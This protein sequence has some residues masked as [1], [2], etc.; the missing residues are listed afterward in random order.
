MRIEEVSPLKSNQLAKDYSQDFERIDRFFTYNPYEG[1][2]WKG[3][4]DWLAASNIKHRDQLTEALL[5]YNQGVGNN[6]ALGNIEKLKNEDVF[7]IIGGQQAGV[8]TG[9]LHVIHKAVTILQLCRDVE[10]RKGIKV[11]PVFWIASEDHDY[12]EV[13]HTYVETGQEQNP[14]K[15]QLHKK[16]VQK[17][18]L[19][20]L[21]IN[22]AEFAHV[23]Q[24]CFSYLPDS[25]HQPDLLATLL[26]FSQ[27][28]K[29]LPDFFA[30]IMAW[31][32]EKH[33]LV[34]V[35]S[36]DPKIRELEKHVF[37]QLMKSDPSSRLLST[38]K[39]LQEIGYPS[40]LEVEPENAHFFVYCNGERELMVRK[41]GGFVSK[42]GRYAFSQNE[43]EQLLEENPSSFSANVVTRPIMQEHLF[44]VLAFVGGP[45][46]VA[47]WAQLKGI[48]EMFSMQMPIVYPRMTFTIVERSIEKYMKRFGI[49][50]F[51]VHDRWEQLQKEWLNQQ[52]PLPLESEFRSLK[53]Q[54][55]TLYLPFLEKLVQIEP[56]VEKL[57]EDNLSRILSH[58][59]F[60]EKKTWDATVQRHRA[61][62]IQW[63]KVR[64]SL[65]PLEKPQERVYN[66]FGY[67]NTYGTSFI[68]ELVE[69]RIPLTAN[70]KLLYI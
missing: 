4:A 33:G 29:G 64:N 69:M 28:S 24:Q 35:D 25:Q 58:L 46:E 16:V 1:N 56:G 36:A 68:D 54:V 21:E 3:R 10:Q 6:G 42:T 15:I 45:G 32:F 11:V 70:H 30:R 65:F 34:L 53:S 39:E 60:L 40:Q 31:L 22:S 12:D 50:F 63:E 8:L 9:P 37:S 13:N 48:F 52:N 57:G 66:V 61:A 27:Q 23:I 7:V 26:D 17:K 44:P 59:D 47:Y 20:D 62:L 55:K 51:D 67:L 14:K 41:E 5:Q 18:S 43:L 2:S 49:S 38:Q 19:S